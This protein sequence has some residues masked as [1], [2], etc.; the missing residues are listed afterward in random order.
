[1]TRPRPA[2]T[3]VRLLVAAVATLTASLALTTSAAAGVAVELLPDLRIAAPDDLTVCGAPTTGTFQ[4]E[5]C[6][7]ETAGD[8]WLRFDSLLMNVGKGTFRL[9]ARRSSTAEDHMHATQWIRR[10]DWTWAKRQT[11]ATL[12]WAQD[13][14]GHPHWHTQ[15]VER[16]QLLKLPSAF[17]GGAKVGVK[18][19]YC[20]F[21]GQSVR[22]DL[23]AARRA[24]LYS[25]YSCGI[26]GQSQEALR[27]KVGLS[28]GWADE[29]PW[30]YAGQR[31]DISDVADGDFLLCLT[32]DPLKQFKELREGN[33]QSWAR[34]RLT[35][36]T[37]PQFKV[38]VEVLSK[39]QGSCQ[40]QL[41]YPIDPL[42]KRR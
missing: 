31:I 19:G 32:A 28:V 6:P 15:G 14:D 33:N 23:P 16:Y 10:S 1:M 42:V 5:N 30:N 2:R 36:Q 22:P 29:Y 7:N 4:T 13:E 35:T 25:F 21:D 8:A 34:I 40:K 20:F 41:P 12:A 11:D 3:A 9:V 24:P 17:P 26:P 18:R 38:N 37:E 27:L 39:G